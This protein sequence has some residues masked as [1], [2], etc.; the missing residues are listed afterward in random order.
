M[1][2]R[3]YETQFKNSMHNNSLTR[4]LDYVLLKNRRK[5]E[6]FLSINSIIS[7]TFLSPA[8]YPKNRSKVKECNKSFMEL[9]NVFYK[10]THYRSPH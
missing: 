1:N 5:H 7:K 3:K 10:S 9:T 8:Q 2:W 6:W 4:I